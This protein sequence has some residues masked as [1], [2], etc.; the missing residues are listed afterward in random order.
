MPTVFVVEDT[1]CEIAGLQIQDDAQCRINAAHLVE[2]EEP[3]AVAE[4]ARV[5]RCA[6]F[7]KYPGAYAADFDLGPKAC[8]TR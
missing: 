4:P 2:A 5:D 6:L 7:G 3:D 1:R 8:G